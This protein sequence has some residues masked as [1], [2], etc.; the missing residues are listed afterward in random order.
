LFSGGEFKSPSEP[1]L[2]LRSSVKWIGATNHSAPQIEKT[3]KQKITKDAKDCPI[4]QDLGPALFPL[5]TPVKFAAHQ[6]FVYF[7]SFC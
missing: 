4:L 5:F 6:T 3:I 1:L 7:V 2:P